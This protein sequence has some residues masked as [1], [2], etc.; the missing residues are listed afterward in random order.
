MSQDTEAMY[1]DPSKLDEL[2]EL[3]D[4]DLEFVADLLETYLDDAKPRANKLKEALASG[5]VDSSAA[6]AHALKSGSANIGASIAAQHFGR[7]EE[8]GRAGSMDSIDSTVERWE[9][10]F[11]R[12]VAEIE[13]WLRDHPV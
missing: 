6:L 5:D 9:A 7:I 12:T 11:D 2:A 8:A 3:A 10:D 1:L 13:A 4:G